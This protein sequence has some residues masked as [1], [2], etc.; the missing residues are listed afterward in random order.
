ME[1]VKQSG[2]S[3]QFA[4]DTLKGDT[5]IVMEAVKKN[6]R[7]LQFASTELKNNL[8]LKNLAENTQQQHQQ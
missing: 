3:L 7:Y 5:E 6:A 4:S 1:A 2:R 8:A